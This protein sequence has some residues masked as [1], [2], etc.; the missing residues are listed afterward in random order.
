MR[1][2]ELKALVKERGL[3]GYSRLRKTKLTA[4]LRSARYQG[5]QRS[6]RPSP[7]HVQAQLVRPRQSSLQEMDIFE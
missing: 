4:L 7:P 1:V 5:P 2:A 6:T 3:R